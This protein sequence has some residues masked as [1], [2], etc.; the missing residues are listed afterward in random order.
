MTLELYHLKRRLFSEGTVLFYYHFMKNIQTSTTPQGASCTRD[1]GVK[2]NSSGIK[3]L[4]EKQIICLTD[5]VKNL[6]V[7]VP[8]ALT[9]EKQVNQI[10]KACYYHICDIGTLRR[11]ITRNACKTLARVLIIY[12]LD[13][14]NALPNGLQGI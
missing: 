3:V 6:G 2:A 13:Y 9:M 8:S 10:F 5:S 11:Y 4:I 12:G 7:Y 1:E 14:G